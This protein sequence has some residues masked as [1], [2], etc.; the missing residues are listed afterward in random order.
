MKKISTGIITFKYTVALG[1]LTL[2]AIASYFILLEDIKSHKTS[3]AVI[4]ISGRQRMLSQRI[5]LNALRLVRSTDISEKQ[6]LRREL[7]NDANLMQ[8]SHN[9]LI[10]GNTNMGVQGNPSPD[11]QKMFFSLPYNLDARVRAYIKSTKSLIHSSDADLVP[12]NHTA[13]VILKKSNE[14]LTSLD[15]LVGQFQDESEYAIT[16]LGK[17]ALMILISVLSLLLLLALFLF[18]PIVKRI[19][20]ESSELERAEEYSRTIMERVAD[21]IIIIDDKGVIESFNTAAEHIFGYSSSQV[22]G[23]NVSML[24]PEIHADK[25]DRYLENYLQKNAEQKI[26]IFKKELEGLRKDR[27]TVPLS[28]SVSEIKIQD[29]RL[30][31]GSLRDITKRKKM[32]DKLKKTAIT[33]ELTGLLNRRGFFTL[34]EKHCKL[35]QRNKRMMSL[36][37]VDLDD[38]KAINDNW[39]HS[40]GDLAIIETAEILKKSFRDSDIIARLGGDEFAVLLT[41]HTES[42]IENVIISN[43]MDNLNVHNA[44]GNQNHTLSLSMGFAHFD[45]DKMAS[46]D[47]I[48]AEADSMM[49][50]A[51]K[52]KSD[53]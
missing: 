6:K 12:T 10:N 45:P 43:V 47:D 24:M 41:E 52:N 32:E 8:A 44:T 42:N 1:L 7:S 23:R 50:R 36:L 35:A 21:G 33:D 17:I 9:A 34:S 14:I 28:V 4:N 19:K 20:Q 37:Y 3:A 11:V 29:R 51:K 18:R 40:E 30:F 22:K 53:S 49:Y 5:A 13:G 16:G 46:I 39:G 27:S 15:T 38:M 2:L 31:I 26:N 48:V 25:H